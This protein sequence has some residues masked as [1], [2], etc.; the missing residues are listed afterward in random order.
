M[1]LENQKRSLNTNEQ[2]IVGV[3]IEVKKRTEVDDDFKGIFHGDTVIERGTYTYWYPVKN[4]SYAR[5]VN[6]LNWKYGFKVRYGICGS[7]E[8]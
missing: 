1:S 6:K 7:M 3:R 4:T 2:I 8:I 5:L